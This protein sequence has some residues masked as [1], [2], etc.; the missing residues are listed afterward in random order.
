MLNKAFFCNCH[1]NFSGQVQNVFVNEDDG[2]V[3]LYFTNPPK[4]I[5]HVRQIGRVEC[6]KIEIIRKNMQVIHSAPFPLLL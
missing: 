3:P 5:T 6:Y 1:D 2:K 4:K